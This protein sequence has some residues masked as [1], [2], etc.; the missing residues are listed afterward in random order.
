M[1]WIADKDRELLL[2]AANDGGVLTVI[3]GEAPEDQVQLSRIIELCRAGFFRRARIMIRPDVDEA[4]HEFSLTRSGA[5]LA[6]YVA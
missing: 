2:K 5:R 4:I 3:G 1:S 6:K